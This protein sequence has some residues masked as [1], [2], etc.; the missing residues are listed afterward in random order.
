MVL[1]QTLS[2]ATVLISASL[3]QTPPGVSPSASANLGVTYPHNVVVSPPGVLLPQNEVATQPTIFA[4]PG[5]SPTSSYI[6]FMLDIDTI[7]NST[8]TN[9]LHWFEPNFTMHSSSRSRELFNSSDVDVAS[10]IA[11]APLPGPAHRYVFTLFERPEHFVFPAC[12]DSI[13]PPTAAAR[14]GFNLSEFVSVARLGSPVAGNYFRVQNDTTTAP[15]VVTAT[16]L[17]SAACSPTRA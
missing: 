15:P 10:Y 12:Y 11:P 13:F 8:A 1:L 16:S 3:A 14:V 6:L 7:L 9:V 4:Q 2:L 5:A 17:S